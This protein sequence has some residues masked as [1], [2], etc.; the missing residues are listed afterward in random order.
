MMFDTA[1]AFIYSV[2]TF[3]SYY[4][5]FLQKNA[6]FKELV[7]GH[8]LWQSVYFVAVITGICIASLVKSEV[9]NKDYYGDLFEIYFYSTFHRE[10]KLL[11]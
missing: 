1:V 8:Y 7:L 6:I 9:I 2:L 10:R 11:T 5:Y 4:Q 3:Y